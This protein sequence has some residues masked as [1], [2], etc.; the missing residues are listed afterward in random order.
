MKIKTCIAYLLLSALLTGVCCAE[1]A[2]C[3]LRIARNGRLATVAT[4]AAPEGFVSSPELSTTSDGTEYYFVPSDASSPV[5]FLYYTAGSGNPRALAE[6][7]LDSYGV[8]YDEF[9]AGGIREEELAS[10]RCLRFDYTCAYPD[11]TGDHTVYE[12]T[13][14]GYIFLD[15]GEFIACIVSLAF[16]D[17]SDYLAEEALTA[18]QD[19][20]LSAILPE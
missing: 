8:F 16:D 13:A 1:A 5:R 12:Q 11:R 20:A 19:G 14:V 17:P 3:P 10:Q 6:A 4:I 9:Q 18:Q 2:G 7:A 15:G